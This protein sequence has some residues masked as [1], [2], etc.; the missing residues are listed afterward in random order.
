M[1]TLKQFT[2]LAVLCVIIITVFVCCGRPNWELGDGWVEISIHSISSLP[3]KTQYYE[4]ERFDPTGLEL[5]INEQYAD[6]GKLTNKKRTK[7]VKWNGNETFWTFEIGYLTVGQSSKTGY[8]RFYGAGGIPEHIDQYS[9]P[10]TVIQLPP[11]ATITVINESSYNIVS[12]YIINPENSSDFYG[13][14]NGYYPGLVRKNE[15]LSYDEQLKGKNITNYRCKIIYYEDTR[16]PEGNYT[17]Y[18]IPYEVEFSGINI[19]G[20]KTTMVTLTSDCEI[21]VVNPL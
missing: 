18:G 21:I 11:P 19:M 3:N 16:P 12:I 8:Y 14:S 5:M 6:N 17:L 4:G 13:N 2:F 15:S 10:I 20:G 9:I 1:K 7:K